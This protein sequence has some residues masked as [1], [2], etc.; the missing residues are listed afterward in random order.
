MFIRNVR[1][2]ALS[3]IQIFAQPARYQDK[4][5]FDAGNFYW[6]VTIN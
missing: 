3:G 6:I 1:E 5:L 2:N 4:Y